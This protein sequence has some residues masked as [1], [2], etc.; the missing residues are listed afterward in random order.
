MATS[1]LLPSDGS[2]PRSIFP[3]GIRTSGKLNPLFDLMTPTANFPERITG[4]TVWRAEDYA[5]KPEQ[6]IHRFTPD[7]QREISG[8]A[9]AFIA[10]GHPLTGITR[11]C[12]LNLY[13]SA[14]HTQSHIC[15]KTSPCLSY[16]G[17]LTTCAMI[18]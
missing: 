10:A 14:Q 13:F 18:C 4:P 15:R 2:A 3:D 11:V 6:W 7:E 1:V 17:F 16:Q 5:D 12:L 8:A 9:D